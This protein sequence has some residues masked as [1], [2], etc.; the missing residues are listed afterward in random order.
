MV[1]LIIA[2]IAGRMGQRIHALAQKETG[3]EV[4]YGLESSKTPTLLNGVRDRIAR[5]WPS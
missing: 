4:V 2:G 1:R 5:T 3:L